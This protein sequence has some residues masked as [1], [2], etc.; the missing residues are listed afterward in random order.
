[1]AD[2][3]GVWA[4][5]GHGSSG[6]A[7]FI[8]L[9]V[10]WQGMM[11]VMMAPAVVPWVLTLARLLNAQTGISRLAYLV[12][13]VAGYFAVWLCYSTAAAAA[14]SALRHSQLLD[15]SDALGGRLGGVVLLGAGITQ[16]TAFKRACL[17]DCRNPLGFFLSRWRDGLRGAFEVGARHGAHCVGCCWALMAVS[18]VTGVMNLLWM[19]VLTMLV[20]LEQL[21]P[22]GDAVRRVA[23][24]ALAAA[25]LFVLVSGSG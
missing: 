19:A 22:R 15:A 17:S 2:T 7:S 13:F 4:H 9:V 6:P 20:T 10:M 3:V 18:F 11:V 16:W 25:G 12:T 21:A 5:A 8:A 1:M 23:G 24:V 14:Q